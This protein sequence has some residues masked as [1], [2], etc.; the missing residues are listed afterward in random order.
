MGRFLLLLGWEHG[1]LV[2]GQRTDQPAPLCNQLAVWSSPVQQSERCD[3]R[4][5]KRRPPKLGQCS[6][7]VANGDGPAESAFGLDKQK[8]DA[9]FRLEAMKAVG[10]HDRIGGG[11]RSIPGD[12]PERPPKAEGR[13]K[14]VV[15]VD[16]GASLFSFEAGGINEPEAGAFPQHD[17]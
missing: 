4:R 1:A 5:E 2:E 17:T 9:T 8:R 10:R 14:G 12:Q 16:V 7:Y 15:G 3:F 11:A 6:V 13:L